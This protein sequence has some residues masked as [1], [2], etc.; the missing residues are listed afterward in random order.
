M[1]S[2]KKILTDYYIGK[3]FKFLE[4]DDEDFKSWLKDKPERFQKALDHPHIN[5]YVYEKFPTEDV[6]RKIKD[7]ENPGL[8]PDILCCF[9]DVQL[10]EVELT[11]TKIY[12]YDQFLI[13]SFKETRKECEI[14]L[15]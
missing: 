9:K 4:L 1:N 5:L 14:F 8:I 10:K 11:I 7:A 3:K 6:E 2:P 13:M 12:C 15:N